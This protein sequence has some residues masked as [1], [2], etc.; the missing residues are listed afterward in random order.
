MRLRPS[1][2]PSGNAR[3]ATRV[4]FLGLK[5]GANE[6]LPSARCAV[7]CPLA[8]RCGS[9]QVFDPLHLQVVPEWHRHARRM[10]H[11][12][13]EH[14]P[15]DLFGRSHLPRSNQYLADCSMAL[16]GSGVQRRKVIFPSGAWVGLDWDRKQKPNSL[17]VSR[18]GGQV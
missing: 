6:P 11:C 14:I 18:C 5:Y 1:D 13:A 12:E 17:D 2:L 16:H 15:A 10:L 4:F 3:S 9:S 8:V 7:R